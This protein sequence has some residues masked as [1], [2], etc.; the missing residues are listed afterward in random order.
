MP[1]VLESLRLFKTRGVK[2]RFDNGKSTPV[3]KEKKNAQAKLRSTSSPVAQ[4]SCCLR[5]Q[6]KQTPSSTVAP[7]CDKPP[8]YCMVWNLASRPSATARRAT[9]TRSGSPRLNCGTGGGN[10]GGSGSRGNSSV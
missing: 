6:V 10:T 7:A 4:S 2:H 3:E 1:L 9:K 5:K 8:Q